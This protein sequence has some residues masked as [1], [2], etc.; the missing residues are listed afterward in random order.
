MDDSEQSEF[1]LVTVASGSS[2]EMDLLRSYLEAQ[3]LQV[4]L[5]GEYTG[6]LAP[7]VAG[8]GGAAA[9]QMLVPEDQA[10]M[11]QELIENWQ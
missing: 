10:A 1:S 3:G 9:V 8:S 7:Y 4:F 11:A 5:Q 2:M 6:Q